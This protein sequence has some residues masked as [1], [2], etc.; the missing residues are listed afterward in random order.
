MGIKQK[1]KTGLE[2]DVIYN[3]RMYC[4]LCNNPK[5][6]RYA[7]KQLSRRR[8]RERKININFFC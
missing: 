7:K 2:V 6:V 3:R 5:L 4:Y 1:L 8:R